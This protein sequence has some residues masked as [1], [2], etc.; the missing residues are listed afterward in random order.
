MP[1][2]RAA[3]PAL[4][5]TELQGLHS[6][7]ARPRRKWRS[8]IRRAGGRDCGWLRRRT[9]HL[10][11]ARPA[12]LRTLRYPDPAAL[13]TCSGGVYTRTKLHRGDTVL[14]FP[15]SSRLFPPYSAIAFPSRRYGRSPVSP[16]GARPSRLW[17]TAGIPLR[18]VTALMPNAE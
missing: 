18:G 6:W 10:R 4:E 12:R 14:L 1:E 13:L 9:G 5:R 15:L 2:G 8:R 11:P 3:V 16:C 17:P 7:I